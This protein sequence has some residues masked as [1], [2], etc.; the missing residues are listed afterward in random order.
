[1][2]NVEIRDL[3]VIIK[4]DC[5]DYT[6]FIPNHLETPTLLRAEIDREEVVLHCKRPVHTDLYHPIRMVVYQQ[7]D[8]SFIQT[9]H[10]SDYVINSKGL[11][12]VIRMPK[13]EGTYKIKA[14]NTLSG[15]KFSR[16]TFFIGNPN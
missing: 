3:E 1:M 13:I 14:E 10:K 12:V 4:K 6:K 16:Q 5:L 15:S 7:K 8:D 9:N 2:I 11:E